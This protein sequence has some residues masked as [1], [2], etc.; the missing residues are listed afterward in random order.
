MRDRLTELRHHPV[1]RMTS[2]IGN[3]KTRSGLR[4]RWIAIYL[5][6]PAERF[7][8]LSEQLAVTGRHSRAPLPE[9]WIHRNRRFLRDSS[10]PPDCADDCDKL[11][12]LELVSFAETKVV[13]PVQCRSLLRAESSEAAPG[14]AWLSSAREAFPHLALRR[15]IRLAPPVSSRT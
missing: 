8:T 5:S 11:A 7:R 9:R 14:F 2:S 1:C 6:R 15:N 12:D 3:R 4:P 13:I 10:Q